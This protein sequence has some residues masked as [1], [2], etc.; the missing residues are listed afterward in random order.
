MEAG[1]KDG[2]GGDQAVELNG[3]EG[4]ENHVEEGSAS[5]MPAVQTHPAA[6]IGHKDAI[7]VRI[8]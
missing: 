2:Q 3:E 6:Q 4:S 7:N 5:E 1:P 8:R